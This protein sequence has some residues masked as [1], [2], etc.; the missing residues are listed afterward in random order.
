VDGFIP[1]L[2][3][4]FQAY[5]VLVIA[6]DIRQLEHIEYT[7]APDII[8]E[9]AGHYRESR[10]CRIRRFGEIGC[11]AISSDTDYQM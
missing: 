7:P 9:G 1:P 3:M 11:K 6:S 5:N 2:F 10:I 4:E 8:H